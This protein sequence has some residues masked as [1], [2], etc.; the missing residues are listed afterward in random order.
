MTT[1][2]SIRKKCF[3]ALPERAT[4]PQNVKGRNSVKN[5]ENGWKEEGLAVVG[6]DA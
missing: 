5:D 3:T 1:P 2:F 4:Q 6:D